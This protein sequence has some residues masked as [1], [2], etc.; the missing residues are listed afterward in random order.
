MPDTFACRLTA[1]LPS[2]IAT[3]AVHS[4]NPLEIL[5]RCLAK[6]LHEKI[7]T[8]GRVR[9]LKWPIQGFDEHI[10]ACLVNANTLEI[11]CHGGVAITDAI[12]KALEE[13]GCSIIDQ[14]VW[15]DATQ[16]IKS[17]P[18]NSIRLLC[19][20]E[21]LQAWSEK[22]AG[23]LLDQASGVLFDFFQQLVRLLNERNFE[24]ARDLVERSS[25]WNA[26]G[27]HLVKPWSIV[28]AGPPNAG[29][30]SLINA[31]TGQSVAIVHHE[32]GTTRD[33]IEARTHVDGWP[34][35]LTDTAGLRETN[36]AI[37]QQG[38]EFAK[39]RIEQAD[40][41]VLVV[42]STVG[43]TTEHDAILRQCDNHERLVRAI[44]AWNKSDLMPQEWSPVMPCELPAIQCSAEKD[45][46]CLLDTI[47]SCLIPQQPDPGEPIV[48]D[49]QHQELLSEI[50]RLLQSPVAQ[51]S[52]SKLKLLAQL[53][54]QEH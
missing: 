17:D 2:A 53:L 39:E 9:F 42:D 16:R 33:W 18:K 20:R 36:E 5:G 46:S 7:W 11:H 50:H 43:W 23:V 35:S 44:V 38:V 13:Q 41:V 30:S 3:I 32:A 34:V 10:V 15:T 4:P 19:E 25:R 45:V 22:A 54:L 48:F 24:L 8:I 14:Q 31:L 1:P 21:L 37:E 28:L 49:Q 51:A 12:L 26:I 47:S 27:R 40:L 52:E 6:P 29:K